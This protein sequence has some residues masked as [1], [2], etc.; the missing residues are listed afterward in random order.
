MTFLTVSAWS[1]EDKIKSTIET[2]F[3]LIENREIAKALDYVH[4]ELIDMLGKDFYVDQY[5]MIFNSP[6]IEISLDSFKTKSISEGF[7]YEEQ[8]Y[9][10]V[11]YA[12]NMT[13]KVDMSD[14]KEGFFAQLLLGS[15]QGKFGKENVTFQEPGTYVIDVRKDMYAIQSPAFEG[16]K[17]IEYE[18]SMNMFLEKIIPTTVRTHYNN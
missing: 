11:K 13:F 10:L 8:T 5:D 17:I 4:P 6:G 15:Y 9:V 3:G 2:Y 7:K 18:E 14:D 16:W 12:H 1:Q